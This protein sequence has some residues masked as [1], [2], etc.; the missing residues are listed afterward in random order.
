MVQLGGLYRAEVVN[1]VD[2]DA[3]GRIEV[4]VPEVSPGSVWAERCAPLGSLRFP[5]EPP[6]PGATVWVMF[7]RG[8]PSFPVVVGQIDEPIGSTVSIGIETGARIELST[9]GL[10]LDNGKGA[11]IELAGPAVTINNGALEIV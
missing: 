10:V 8:D 1:G 9:A 6:S 7:E 5:S 11:R 3:R 2:P 4:A